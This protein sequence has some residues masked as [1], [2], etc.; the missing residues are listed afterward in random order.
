MGCDAFHLVPGIPGLLAHL[1]DSV[2]DFGVGATAPVAVGFRSCFFFAREFAES[3]IDSSSLFIP[4]GSL[5]HDALLHSF[6]LKGSPV[7]FACLK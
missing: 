1:G 4:S 2:E 3:F 5:G 6:D 7:S